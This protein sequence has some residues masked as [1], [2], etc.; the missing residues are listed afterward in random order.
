MTYA[1]CGFSNFGSIGVQIGGLG[2][3]APSRQGDL[4]RLGFRAML[5]GTLA[6]CLTACVAGTIL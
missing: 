5:G 4:A 3:M 6:C 2:G 1:L